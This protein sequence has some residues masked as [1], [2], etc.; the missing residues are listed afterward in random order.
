M[1]NKIKTK[2]MIRITIF[3]I[4]I[5]GGM[6]LNYAVFAKDFYIYKTRQNMVE[7]FRELSRMNLEKMGATETR[8]LDDLV[9]QGFVS[10]GVLNIENYKENPETVIND[11]HIELMGK[12]KKSGGTVYIRTTL[13]IKS[14]AGSVEVMSR[15][16]LAEMVV[17]LI[18]GMIF[19][20]YQAHRTIRPIEE[21]G[22]MAQKMKMV[23]EIMEQVISS[24]M[25]K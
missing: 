16:M 2:Y 24:P 8:V 22:K 12:V 21:L 19:G 20:F 17:A 3:L 10:F 13:N 14:L 25:M 18:L 5:V 7:N 1:K 6:I 23:K 15:F 9:S 11:N 4:G